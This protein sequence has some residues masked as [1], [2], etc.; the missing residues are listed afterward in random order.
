MADT[1]LNRLTMTARQAQHM[2]QLL[3]QNTKGYDRAQLRKLDRLGETIEEHASELV[4]KHEALLS[5]SNAK[6]RLPSTTMAE[7][8]ELQKTYSVES[9]KL[10]DTVGA[11]EFSLLLDKSEVDFLNHAWSQ[12]GAFRGMKDIRQIIEA[13]YVAL[14]S[15]K[16]VPV[17]ETVDESLQ[18]GDKADGDRMDG[19]ES[20]GENPT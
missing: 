16:S 13:I 15:I 9:K 6:A 7:A 1:K 8:N 2:L 11:V 20:S 12:I 5:E 17:Q 3:E 4:E 18:K 14:E 10:N 19:V